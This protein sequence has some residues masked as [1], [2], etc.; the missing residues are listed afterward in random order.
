M[1]KADHEW[2]QAVVTFAANAETAADVEALLAAGPHGAAGAML[3][4]LAGGVQVWVG[5]YLGD[6]VVL[7][8]GLAEKSGLRVG[9]VATVGRGDGDGDISLKLADGTDLRGYFQ[10]ADLATTVPPGGRL[11]HVAAFFG[12]PAA[13]VGALLAADPSVAG[14]ADGSGRLPLNLAVA[15][16][17]SGEALA[18]LHAAHPAAELELTVLAEYIVAVAETAADVEALLAAGPAGAA[19][20]ELPG[21]A[22]GVQV[23]IGRKVGDAVVLR[24]GLAEKSGLRVGQVA[25]VRT[26]DGDDYIN[27]KQTDGMDVR[28]YFQRADLATAVMPAGGRLLHVAAVCGRP[29]AVVGAVLAA[30]PSAAGVADGSG[31]LPLELLL[32]SSPPPSDEAVLWVALAAP[33]AAGKDGRRALHLV[34]EHKRSAAVVSS[35]LKTNTS[36]LTLSDRQGRQPW[37]VLEEDE[38]TQFPELLPSDQLRERVRATLDGGRLAELGSLHLRG[39]IL[40]EE[41]AGWRTRQGHALREACLADNEVQVRQLTL[42][43][44]QRMPKVATLSRRWPGTL[45]AAGVQSQSLCML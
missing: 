20:A 12:R 7:R 24:A 21:L 35:V 28:Y 27:L 15:A 45:L 43:A 4:D 22:G 44:W 33:L 37:Q 5:R 42:I 31:R 13:V 2:V 14:M 9:Q 40:L 32:A 34:L 29:A 39:D 30:E 10:R 19:G 25:T 6:A 36:V 41:Y 17:C 23:G 26:V 8:A 11:L 3:L 38:H 1:K 18:V 16:G